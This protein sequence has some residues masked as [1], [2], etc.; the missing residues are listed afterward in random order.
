MKTTDVGISLNHLMQ[1]KIALYVSTY[2]LGHHQSLFY[3]SFLYFE[4][5][6]Q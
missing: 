5:F 2:N 3:V 6:H 4:Y 1:R